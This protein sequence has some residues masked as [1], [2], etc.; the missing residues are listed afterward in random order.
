MKWR[1]VI[2]SEQVGKSQIVMKVSK[3]VVNKNVGR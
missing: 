1:Y 3:Y 2:G